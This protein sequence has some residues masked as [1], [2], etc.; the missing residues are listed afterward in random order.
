MNCK[1]TA[2]AVGSPSGRVAKRG[3]DNAAPDSL[4][5]FE[6]LLWGGE[7]EKGNE[8]KVGEKERKQGDGRE[9]RTPL[10]NNFLVTALLRWDD[11]VSARYWS[12][13]S[14]VASLKQCMRAPSCTTMRSDIVFTALHGMQTRSSD[15]NSVRLSVRP[16]VC[17][18][19]VLWQNGRKICPD[20]YTIYERPYSLVFWEEEW[21]L[22]ATP[23]TWNLGSTGPHWIKIADFEPIIAV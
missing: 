6:G 14:G 11:A 8:R 16:S 7:K 4:D 22:G 5:G 18:T 21:L 19:R 15:E 2:S 9:G 3:A 13:W 12:W 10:R 20:L 1:V 23:S 17:H